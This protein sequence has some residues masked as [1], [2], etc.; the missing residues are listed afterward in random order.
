MSSWEENRF[1]ELDA[2]ETVLLYKPQP[3]SI[4]YRWEG[5]TK[6]YTPDILVIY[7]ARLPEVEEIKPRRR[8]EGDKTGRIAAKFA[9]GQKYCADRGWLFRVIDTKPEGKV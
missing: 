5:A 4:P 3:F 8:I 9:A 1:V 6:H 7:E 2:D